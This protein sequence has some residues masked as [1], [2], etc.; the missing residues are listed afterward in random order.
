MAQMR[1]EWFKFCFSKTDSHAEPFLQHA[2]DGAL[3]GIDS[4]GQ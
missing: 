4:M 3:E 2:S 1:S